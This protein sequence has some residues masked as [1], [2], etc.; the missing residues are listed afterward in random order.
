M[1]SRDRAMAMQM[2]VGV[3]CRLVGAPETLRAEIRRQLTVD[4]PKYQAAARYGRWVGRQLKPKLHFFRENSAIIHFPR[5]FA[6]QAVLLCRRLGLDDPVILDQRLLLEPLDLRFHGELRPY[7][8]E[9]VAAVCGRSFGVLEAATGSGKTVMALAVIA[10]RQQPTLILVHSKELFHQW[11]QRIHDFLQLEA[12]LAGD[13]QCAPAPITVGIVNTVRRRLEE[14]APRFGQLVVDE[15]HRVPATLFTDVVS[16]FASHYLLGLSATAFRRDNGL[17][18]MIY[19]YM[20]DR[21]HGV[22][23]AELAAAG[24]VARPELLQTATDFRSHYSGDYATLLKKITSDEARNRL[25]VHDVA[26]AAGRDEAGSILVVSDRVAHC[27]ILCDGLRELGVDAHLLTGQT[28]A[29]ERVRVVDLVRFGT[30]RVLV[31]TLQL[32]GE[33]FDCPGLTTLFL[34]TPIKFEGRFLQVVGRIMRPAAGKKPVVHDYVDVSI[35][36]LRRSAE[37]RAAVFERL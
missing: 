2:I 3:E 21:V 14:L 6:N 13:G 32:I 34:A 11:R 23:R 24:A 31:A 18:K 36:P 26:A 17:T 27:E 10:R 30:V 19:G 33:G 7:Q 37:H 22:D 4:N 12:G 9:A 20:G 8:E 15:C 25:I 5:G 1:D 28:Q 16:G 35:P 29:E